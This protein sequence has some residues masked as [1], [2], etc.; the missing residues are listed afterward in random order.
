M[1]GSLSSTLPNPFKV[2]LHAIKV[3]AIGT[4]MFLRTVESVKSRCNRE[5]GSLALRCSNNAFAIPKFPSAFSKSIGL[6]LCGMADEPISPALICC[7]K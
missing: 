2:D 4:P 3:C 7:R 5:M 1:A 6:T